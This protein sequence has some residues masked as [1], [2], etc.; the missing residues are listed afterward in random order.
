MEPM[1]FPGNLEMY[2][3][4]NVENEM[5]NMGNLDFNIESRNHHRHPLD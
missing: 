2:R 3:M 1:I 4:E 5:S